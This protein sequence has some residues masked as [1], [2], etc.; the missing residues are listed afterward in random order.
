MKKNIYCV[1]EGKKPPALSQSRLPAATSQP[2]SS[3]Q[4]GVP[5]MFTLAVL[6]LGQGAILKTCWIGG[7]ARQGRMLTGLLGVNIMGV[8]WHGRKGCWQDSSR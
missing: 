3:G 1:E 4:V 6:R 2:I 5:I 8:G 7:E